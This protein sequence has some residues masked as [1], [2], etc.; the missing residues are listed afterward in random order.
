MSDINITEGNKKMAEFCGYVYVPYNKDVKQTAGWWLKEAPMIDYM[1]AGKGE[2]GNAYLGRK[3]NDLKFY[4]FDYLMGLVIP[5]IEK[6]GY[7][8][9]I[10]TDVIEIYTSGYQHITHVCIEGFSDKKR[11]LWDACLKFIEKYNNNDIQQPT[12]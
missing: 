12:K 5:K 1:L 10:D 3:H 7:G 4:G 9:F 6:L 8:I 2:T 11:A